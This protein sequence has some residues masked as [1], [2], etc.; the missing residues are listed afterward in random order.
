MSRLSLVLSIVYFLVVLAYGIVLFT[1]TKTVRMTDF[2]TVWVLLLL[3]IGNT[4]IMRL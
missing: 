4:I 2:V 1:W 3:S